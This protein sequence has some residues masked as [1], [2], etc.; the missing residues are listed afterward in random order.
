MP[1]V[2]TI[3]EA[4]R[5]L[6]PQ[7]STSCNL[8]L[9]DKLTLTFMSITGGYLIDIR[10]LQKKSKREKRREKREINIVCDPHIHVV[11]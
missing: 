2:P 8:A 6:Q 10:Q 9:R 5:I 7:W 11:T 1:D 4:M 3:N